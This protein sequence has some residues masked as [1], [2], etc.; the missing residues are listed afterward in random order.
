[1]R[2]Q[3]AEI[4]ENILRDLNLVTNGKTE[5]CPATVQ[6]LFSHCPATVQP[7]SSRTRIQSKFFFLAS[8][9][10]FSAFTSTNVLARGPQRSPALCGG[11]AEITEGSMLLFF[12][13]ACPILGR[14]REVRTK[15]PGL[16]SNT[17]YPMRCSCS[18][19][20]FF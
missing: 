8:A 2:Q 20:G 9:K 14:R 4:R 16:D 5:S 7:L 13:L 10:I 6:P 19:K 1:M 17:I 12:V 15:M 11:T 18:G 3:S